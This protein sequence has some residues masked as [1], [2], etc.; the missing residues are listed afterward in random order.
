MMMMVYDF[1]STGSGLKPYVKGSQELHSYGVIYL[2]MRLGENLSGSLMRI[3][4]HQM[5]KKQLHVNCG[6]V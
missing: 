1:L 3:T 6:M 2:G 4:K 5:E